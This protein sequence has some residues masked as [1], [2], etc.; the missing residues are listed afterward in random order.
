MSERRIRRPKAY[1]NFMSEVCK[2]ENR[3]FSSYKDFLV[4][5]ASYGASK[6]ERVPFESTAEQ[7]NLST[8]KNKDID[9]INI[10][11][12][13][14]TNDPKVLVDERSEERYKIFEEYAHSGLKLLHTMYTE[15][16]DCGTDFF[17]DLVLK[18]LVQ[19]NIDP[20]ESII[21]GFGS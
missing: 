8:F 5:C 17:S 19:R 15:S 16:I 10:L 18:H 9:F 4:F 11:A 3:I 7:I 2:G 6:G 20:V 12:V 21:S 1:E 13:W 14:E